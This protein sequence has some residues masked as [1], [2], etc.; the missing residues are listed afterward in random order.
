MFLLGWFPPEVHRVLIE[1]GSVAGAAES[2]QEF[3][4]I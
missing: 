4:G 1:E 2:S 3:E